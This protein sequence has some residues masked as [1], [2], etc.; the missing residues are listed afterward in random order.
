MRLSDLKRLNFQLGLKVIAGYFG[1]KVLRRKLVHQQE[2]LISYLRHLAKLNIYHRKSIGKYFLVQ[3][4]SYGLFY[5]RKPFSSDYKVFRQI[6]NDREYLELANIVDAN[7]KNDKISIIDGGANIGLTTIYLNHF[8]KSRKKLLSI[9]IEPFKDN[10]DS[11]K[12]NMEVQ[13]IDGVY[14]ENAGF[15]NKKCFLKIDHS[16]RD[17]MEWSTQIVEASEETDLTSVEVAEVMDKY[18]LEDVDVLKLDIEGAERFLFED[19][20]YAAKFLRRIKVVAIELHREYDVEEKIKSI[21]QKNGFSL[22]KNMHTFIG[23]RQP[24]IA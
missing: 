4:P 5:L 23:T 11:A 17:G 18:Q 3:S 14:Y 1:S 19:E 16:Y 13:G 10:L 21:L 24:A 22:I 12:K 8:F 9:L 7:C 20:E 15:H 6:F 2:E